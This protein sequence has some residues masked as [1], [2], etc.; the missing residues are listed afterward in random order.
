MKIQDYSA[1]KPYLIGCVFCMLLI[2]IAGIMSL[3]GDTI[4]WKWLFCVAMAISFVIS[5]ILLFRFRLVTKDSPKKQASN[6]QNPNYPDLP[7]RKMR[8]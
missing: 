4:V 3:M 5:I 7:I 1:K 6:S 8:N 2:I